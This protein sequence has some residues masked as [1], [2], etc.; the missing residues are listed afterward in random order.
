MVNPAISVAQAFAADLIRGEL[1]CRV[2]AGVLAV[3][4]EAPGD[5]NVRIDPTGHDG[6]AAQIV[7]NRRSLRVEC[8]NLRAFDND[9]CLRGNMPA[10]IEELCLWR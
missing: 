3:R 6:E 9:A 7:I 10:S 8:D 2:G 4:P 5:V 1:R